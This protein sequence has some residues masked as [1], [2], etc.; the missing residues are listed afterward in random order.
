MLCKKSWWAVDEVQLIND[1]QCSWWVVVADKVPTAL[2]H[3]YMDVSLHQGTVA[4]TV[5][6]AV[7]TSDTRGPQY[8]SSHCEIL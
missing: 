7:V 8:K 5:V 6:G 4:L 1:D 3:T 2:S